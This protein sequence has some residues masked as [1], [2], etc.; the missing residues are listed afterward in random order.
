MAK[1]AR[2]LSDIIECLRIESSESV[3][4]FIQNQDKSRSELTSLTIAFFKAEPVLPRP[5][6]DAL[7]R[8]VAFHNRIRNEIGVEGRGNHPRQWPAGVGDPYPASL[9]LHQSFRDKGAHSVD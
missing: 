7:N 3:S 1:I 4:E 8:G 5:M 2:T 9:H 6:A